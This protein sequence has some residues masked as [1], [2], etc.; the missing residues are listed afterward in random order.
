MEN[1][2]HPNVAVLKA[3]PAEEKTGHDGGK[4][5]RHRFA[6]MYH[7]VRHHHYEDRIK[8]KGRFEA[9]QQEPAKEKLE[10]DELDEVDRFP[11]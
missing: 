10:P 6:E 4:G 3:Q 9:M 8:A 7:A 2:S 11:N 1:K 5:L